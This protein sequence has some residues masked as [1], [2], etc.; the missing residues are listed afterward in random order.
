MLKFSEQ[1]NSEN[2]TKTVVRARD[3]KMI[4]DEPAN[5]GGSDD[6]ANPVEYI[7]AAFCGCLNVVGHIIA[8]E[9][10]FGAKRAVY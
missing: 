4:V 2:D 6:D 9:M 3:F 8:K 5:L 10:D 7:L 1:A